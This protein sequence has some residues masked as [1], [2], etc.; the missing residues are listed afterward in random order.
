MNALLS[1]SRGIDGLNQW[2]GVG[3]YWVCLGMSLVSAF[4]AIMRWLG[5]FFQQQLTSNSFIELQWYM[6]GI[7]FLLAAAYVFKNNG[8]VRIDILYG[9]Y[10]PKTQSWVDVIGFFLALLPFYGFMA[11]AGY[12]FAFQSVKIF[13]MSPDPGGLP[14]YPIKVLIPVAC[15][16]LIVQGI[17]EVIKRIAHLSG[18]ERYAP[19]KFQSSREEL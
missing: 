16:L 4:N 5:G 2:I 11:Y 1:L 12:H 14:Y 8:H 15:V 10:T 3:M 18:D 9:R 19:G 7:M 13:E 17:S 6:F